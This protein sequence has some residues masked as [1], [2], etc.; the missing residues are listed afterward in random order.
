MMGVIAWISRQLID[1]MWYRAETLQV[2]DQFLTPKK[3]LP[4]VCYRDL[5]IRAHILRLMS[6]ISK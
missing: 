5:L 3:Q 1:K 4:L 6:E 2:K